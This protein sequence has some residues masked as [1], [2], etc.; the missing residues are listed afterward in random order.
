[1][2]VTKIE[3]LR[4][5]SAIAKIKRRPSDYEIVT[6]NVQT[7]TRHRKQAYEL[8]PAPLVQMNEW[9]K[10]NVFDSPLEHDDWENY[11][12][13]D[14]LV[15]RFYTLNQ[16]AQEQYVDGLLDEH[17]ELG[18]DAGLEGEWLAILQRLYTPRRYLQ[19]ALQMCAA[20]LVQTAPASTITVCAGFQDADEFRWLSRVAY[21][22][23]ELANAH[24]DRGYGDTERDSWEMDPA[25]QGFRE[26]F[27]KV[28]VAYD[29]GEQ[30]VALNL[31]A[32]PAADESLRLFGATG[33][34]YGDALLSLLADNQMRDSDRSRRWSAALVDFAL[35]KSSNRDVMVQWIEKWKPLA[36]QAINAYMEPIPDNEEATKASIKNLE[37]FHRS[38]GLLR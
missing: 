9:Y 24:P 18:H 23:S 35:T 36:I 10:K 2:M 17:D 20:Y 4:T 22:T 19:S 8:S 34:R 11:R 13:P 30:F 33:R 16:D 6:T 5:W 38:L 29:W 32:K 26:L 3:G 37:A 15:Y 12:D 25:W 31:V 28:L 7:R 27:E 14:E 21:R 1:M